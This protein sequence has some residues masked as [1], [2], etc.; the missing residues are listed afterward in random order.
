MAEDGDVPIGPFHCL[1]VITRIAEA[2][3]V[4][5]NLDSWHIGSADALWVRPRP[6]M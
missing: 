2:L 4:S 1:P 6:L 5:M 3:D